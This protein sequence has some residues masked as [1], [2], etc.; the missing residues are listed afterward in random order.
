MRGLVARTWLATR[1]VCIPRLRPLLRFNQDQVVPIE[2]V[3]ALV[4][5]Q[6]EAFVY[7]QPFE[8]IDQFV[9]RGSFVMGDP[10]LYAPVLWP[11]GRPAGP[12]RILVAGCGTVQAAYTAYMNRADEVI[13]IDLSEASLAH[14]RFLQDR[15]GLHN[16]KLYRGDLLD[17]AEFGTAF[18]VIICS[19]VLHHLADPGE[20]LSALRAVL[21]PDGV[22]VLMV[23]GQAARSGV[24][25][26]QDAFRRMRL[27]CDAHGVA[28]VRAILA[29]LP[30]HHCARHYIAMSKELEHDSALVDTFLHAQDRAYTVPQL[31]D[32]V[33]SAGLEFQNWIDSA[34][35]WRNGA[36]GSNSAIANAVDLLPSKEHWAVIEALRQGAGMHGFT[37]RHKG[38]EPA[39]NVDFAQS[40]WQRFTPHLAPGFVKTGSGQY[41]RGSYGLHCSP[42]EEF[43]V[44][45]ID[46]ESKIEGILSLSELSRIP[47]DQLE[48]SGRAFFEHLWKLGHIM[49]ALPQVE[50]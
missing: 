1:R 45:S 43:I 47:H 21:G 31:F 37:A 16:L 6:Y 48:S 5:R 7:P 9:A 46:G 3:S 23:Y 12:L 49:I 11:Y 41:R 22:M 24:Y 18:D 44:G 20:G 19:G 25:M 28:E 29:E 17:A 32:L 15:H 34:E 38:A 42:V 13:G 14:E 27:Q 8:D 39:P 35:Y 50:A 2:D 40:E 4:A 30:S 26:L 36:W 10:S 33:D